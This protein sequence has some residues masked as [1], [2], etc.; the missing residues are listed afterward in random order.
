MDESDDD[1]EKTTATI[2]SKS[3]ENPFD[4]D[5][6]NINQIIKDEIA[7]DKSEKQKD[8][9]G[10]VK[11]IFNEIKTNMKE[12]SCRNIDAVDTG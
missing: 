5:D 9:G 4:S 10:K 3:G 7:I 12:I 1:D 6:E 8:E 11:K 2:N